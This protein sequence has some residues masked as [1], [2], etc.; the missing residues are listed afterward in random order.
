MRDISDQNIVSV[1]VLEVSALSVRPRS[2]PKASFMTCFT[3][4]HNLP[5]NHSAE[6]K[7]LLF[8][9]RSIFLS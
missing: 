4:L 9:L 5:L 1:E 6:R 2:F 7:M 8:G 3:G